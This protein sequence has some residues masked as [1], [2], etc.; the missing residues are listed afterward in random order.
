MVREFI[1]FPAFEFAGLHS[2]TDQP[3]FQIY[4]EG[5]PVPEATDDAT[6]CGLGGEERE[7]GS[8]SFSRWK[9]VCD[10]RDGVD[11]L[12]L[13]Q[14]FSELPEPEQTRPS[15]RPATSDDQQGA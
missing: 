5:V 3:L 15:S 12:R 11:E 13:F 4:P 2:G 1:G 14:S 6:C 10:H 9:P 7:L 8:V